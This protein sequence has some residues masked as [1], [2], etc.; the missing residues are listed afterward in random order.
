M[1]A[2]RGTKAKAGAARPAGRFVRLACF[3]ALV[4]V[5]G[6]VAATVL[7]LPEWARLQRTLHERDCMRANTAEMQSLVKCQQKLIDA[8]RNDP[9]LVKR[10]AMHHGALTPENERVYTHRSG[11]AASTPG[12]IKLPPPRLPDPP[13][14]GIQRLAARLSTGNIRRG[15]LLLAA[16]V[17]MAAIFLFPPASEGPSTAKAAKKS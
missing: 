11:R 17:L 10:L 7:L 12:A 4:C 9:V 3:V 14:A 5:A 6:A 15:L 16:A 8:I 2:R 13:S 1:A